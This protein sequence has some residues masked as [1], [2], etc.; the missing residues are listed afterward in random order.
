M[1]D[2]RVYFRDNRQDFNLNV[3]FTIP[4]QGVTALFGKSG[5]GK[6]TILRFLAGLD[7]PKEGYFKIHDQIW[8]D[9]TQFTPAHKRRVGYV[10]QDANLFAHLNVEENLA[11]GYKRTKNRGNWDQTIQ[12]LGLEPLLKRSPT[13]LSGGEKQRVAIARALLSDPEILLMD[14]PLSALDRF[15]K[16]DIIPYLENLQQ[17]FGVPV[18]FV[19]HDT[20]EVERLATHMVLLEKGQVIASGP[21][22]EILSDP[23]LFIAHS[24]K[25]ASLIEAPLQEIW[26]DEDLSLLDLGSQKLLLSGIIG[27]KGEIKR[28]RINAMDVSLAREKPGPSTIL[29]ALKGTI[30]HIHLLSEGRANILIHVDGHPLIARI[31]QYSL[32]R[33]EFQPGD[34]I[35]AQIKGVSVIN[36]S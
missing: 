5:S 26:P 22:L 24:S 8:Q 10:F 29:N 35:Y 15:S 13:N 3:D 19:S 31:T 16:D 4:K 36:W 28:V 6:T 27:Q 1:S 14:E 30:S 11:F 32:R 25:T 18:V 7:R 23:T 33:F 12:Y 34:E 17:T 20:D 9:H 2:L 21:L